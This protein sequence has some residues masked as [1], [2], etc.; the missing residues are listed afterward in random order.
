[1]KMGFVVALGTFL[2]N[3]LLVPLFFDNRTHMEG[4]FI[5][6]LA[7]VIVLGMYG[8]FS[9]FRRKRKVK[10]TVGQRISSD[11]LKRLLT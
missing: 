3:W 7:A 5:G 9:L 8:V 4:F 6:V 1:M 10:V 11:D 2:G